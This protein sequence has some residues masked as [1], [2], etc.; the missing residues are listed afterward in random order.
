MLHRGMLGGARARTATGSGKCLPYAEQSR[1]FGHFALLPPR[2]ES[3]RPHRLVFVR[4]L[5]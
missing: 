2:R 4:G 1:Q 5:R 3:L